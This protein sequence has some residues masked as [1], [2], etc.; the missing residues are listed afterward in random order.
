M[1]RWPAISP[2][3]ASSR[4]ARSANAAMPIAANMSCAVRSWARAS[5]RRPS[6]RSHSP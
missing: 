6:R 4:R 2:V 3:A 5:A 1:A